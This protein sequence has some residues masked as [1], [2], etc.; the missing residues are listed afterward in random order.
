M[1]FL[2]S[3]PWLLRVPALLSKVL[4]SAQFSSFEVSMVMLASRLVW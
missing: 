3:V 4:V 2:K 1:A